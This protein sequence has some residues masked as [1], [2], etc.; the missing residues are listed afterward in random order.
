[1]SD[2]QPNPEIPAFHSPFEY[3][4]SHFSKQFDATGPFFSIFCH[5]RI[6]LDV[7]RSNLD[8][9]H[10]SLAFAGQTTG[11]YIDVGGRACDRGQWAHR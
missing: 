7:N 11:S 3:R 10:L 5:L 8:D 4:L 9:Y 2:Q 6:I 1:M